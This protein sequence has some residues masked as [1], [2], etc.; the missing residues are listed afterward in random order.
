MTSKDGCGVAD[1]VLCT[2]PVNQQAEIHP[3]QPSKRRK[4]L[5]QHGHIRV[6]DYFWMNQRDDPEVLA[7]LQAENA[8]TQ[9][10]MRDADQLRH[11]LVAEMRSRLVPDDASA[12]FRDSDYF[13]YYRFEPNG[14]YPLYCRKRGSLDTDEELLLDCNELARGHAYFALRGFGVSPDHKLAAFGIDTRGDRFYTI[15][16]IDL[17]TG[18]RVGDDIPDVTANLEWA[19]DNRTLYYTRQHRQTLRDY[20]VWRHSLDGGDDTLVYQED[21]DTCW[22][23]VEKS[24]SGDYLF[25]VSAATLWTEVRYLSAATPDASPRVFLPKSNT[26]EYFVTD[27][28]DRFFILSNDRAV[29]FRVFECPLD[30]TERSAWREIVPHRDNVLVDSFDVFDSFL[31]LS[32]VEDGL[33]RIEFLD[34]ASLTT[35]RLPIDE[36]VY[37]AAPTDNHEYDTRVLRYSVES[38]ITPESTVDFDLDGGTKTLIKQQRVPGG[39][40]TGDYRT[41]RLLVTVRDGTR[42]PVSLAYRR[43]VE[44]DGGAPLLLYAYGSY[45]I[46]SDPDFDTDVLSLLDRGFVYAIAHVRGGSELGRAW[47]HAGRR[48]EKMNTFLDFIDVTKH[49]QKAGYSSPVHTYAMG[50]S[51]GGLLMG[52]IANLAPGLYNGIVAEVPFVDVVTTMLDESIPL[53][54]G[55]FDEWGNPTELGSYHYMLGY[56]PYDNVRAQTY[57][58]MLVTTGYHDSQ[59]QYWEP[60]KW[61]ARL[62]EQKT[63][64]N[65][66]LL[67]TELEAGHSGKSGRYQSLDD[68]AL[69]YG[70]LLMLE[71]GA[72]AR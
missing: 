16:V 36:P 30:G 48:R 39:F 66:V 18:E 22:L 33:D 14:E 59:V 55:E 5:T 1:W 46:S 54:T 12:P 43:D 19:N 20:Q 11:D 57:P 3:P 7:H 32:V 9:A 38:L 21:D 8:Y 61:V 69:V 51:A 67:R 4:T 44:L 40:N 53:T 26:H 65:L 58:H 68:T 52:V 28:R 17:A 13:Y 64:A 71:G 42:V 6:D 34:R 70:F 2:P 15:S 37:T 72:A 50:G 27:G 25:L 23:G 60:A 47:Y 45:G 62:R 10:V 35:S 56:S 63:N 31:A 24:L 41:E 49:L 29:N